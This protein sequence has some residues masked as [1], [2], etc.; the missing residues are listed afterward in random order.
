MTAGQFDA[1]WL[2]DGQRIVWSRL[3]RLGIR[4]D[5]AED[6]FQ[7][8]Y[9]RARVTLDGYNSERGRLSAWLG[10]VVWNTI[11]DRLRQWR[12]RVHAFPIEAAV[13][14]PDPCALPEETMVRFADALSA[15]MSRRDRV[16]ASRLALGYTGREIAVLQGVHESEV[17]QETRRMRSAACGG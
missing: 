5:A 2:T 7:D 11:R 14:Y 12:R 16:L 17:W 6:V 3:S 4:G 10:L 13:D 8:V 9:L 1:W 15:P